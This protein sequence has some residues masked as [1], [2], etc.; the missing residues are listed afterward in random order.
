M[1]SAHLQS[2]G[3]FYV[4]AG[5][6][7][8][9]VGCNTFENEANNVCD[10]H[11]NLSRP[12][13]GF[14]VRAAD[15]RVPHRLPQGVARL[16]G[17]NT[18]ENKA[19]ELLLSAF[20]LSGWRL[21]DLRRCGPD[22]LHRSEQHRICECLATLPIRIIGARGDSS[23]AALEAKSGSL[24]LDDGTRFA[25]NR[26]RVGLAE[27]IYVLPAPQGRY[28]NARKCEVVYAPCTCKSKCSQDMSLNPAATTN[29]GSCTQPPYNIQPCPWSINLTANAFGEE[30]LGLTLEKLLP[31]TYDQPE[32]PVPCSP[33]LLGATADNINGQGQ[34][35]ALC[36]GLCPAGYYCPD[37]ATTVAISCTRGHF[38]PLGA[39]APLPCEEGS[40]STRTN[41]SSAAQ[42]DGTEPGFY[43]ITGSPAP[44][45]CSPGAVAADARM[46]LCAP[47]AEGKF[48]DREQQTECKPCKQGSFCP[49]GAS[50]P[51]SCAKGSYSIST[52]LTSGSEC[53]ETNAG[54][55]AP[56]GSTL[57]TKCS[58]G[59]V[60]PNASMA[61]CDKCEAGKYQADEGELTC[62]ACQP[63]SYCPEGA[64]AALPCK[65]GSYS[66]ST[67][68]TSPSEC[69]KTDAGSFA[70]TGST[71]QT[72]CS[73]GTVAPNASMATCDKCAAGK[74][75]EDEG[76]QACVACEPGLYC[77][78]GASAALS[79]REGSY[80]NAINLTSPNECTKTDAGSFAPTG[81]I[82]Q[83]RCSPGT[84]A[85]NASMGSCLKC[86]AGTFQATP[87]QLMCESC[88][89]G[90]YCA[91][92]AAAA[93]PCAEGTYSNA[94]DL[95]TDAEC[96]PT[97]KGYY[98]PT[99][100]TKQMACS[101]GTVAP[102]A[103]MAICDKCEASKYQASEGKQACVA[104]KPG[105]YCPE[106]ASAALPCKEG[107][108]SNRTDLNSDVQ[109]NGTEP[110]F[111]ATTGST[112]PRP[113]SSG[114]V[115]PNASMAT[116][117]KCDEGKYQAG[118]GQ[119]ICETCR[120]GNY[121]ASTLSCEPCQKGMYS[122]GNAAVECFECPSGEYQP[123]TGKTSCETCGAG[124]YSSNVLSCEPCPVGEYCPDG[125]ERKYCPTGSTT[126][127]N[128]SVNY[129][130]CGCRKGTYNNTAPGDK[131]T[132][133]PCSDDM[134]C[135]RV[136]LSLAT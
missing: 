12:G 28:T 4:G 102:N 77:P 115:Q 43:A 91:E 33:G 119:Q 13:G 10:R 7:A 49:E 14:Y 2:G 26:F 97:A 70:P 90:S 95:R 83:T 60:A 122:P 24:R 62:V 76:E 75:Q 99:G 104:C 57:Q 32:W 15:L 135:K 114:T 44:R 21:F 50:A 80:S 18:F 113:C 34:L 118:E 61:T 98:A 67:N 112:A 52:N 48:Q 54:H 79:C 92:G 64:S 46:G 96:T 42:C 132:C 88:T 53:T 36:A 65:E 101:P 6:V 134:N 35:S 100:S 129:D 63:G 82:E 40:Y 5:G 72:R 11:A 45:P 58:P 39:S 81:S 3:G 19:D 51:L 74:Y 29:S 131:L 37:Y 87:G 85:P 55:F 94:I 109:C 133:T 9:L 103:S 59:T 17:C 69:T 130:D 128:G 136:G 38:C 117:V 93:L 30:I 22:Q 41:L 120:A 31:G 16:V 47:C 116:C 123:E 66:I 125:L 89:P 124:N 71:E 127:G 84:V 68:L 27:V 110:G 105:S 20:W 126:E 111:Y 78:E 25:N 107:S 106:G 23:T 1:S 86:E 8:R 121:S 73:P 108:Y 56:T